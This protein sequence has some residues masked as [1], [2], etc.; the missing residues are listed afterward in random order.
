MPSPNMFN[1]YV[2]DLIVAAE[3]AKQVVTVGEDTV[4][5]LLF[6]DDFVGISET[7]QGLQNK[8]EKA[9]RVE[10]TRKWWVTANAKKC[11]VVVCNEDK[12][13]PVNFCWK[14]GEDELSIVDQYTYLGVE[15]LEDSSS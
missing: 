1:L 8:T 5:G 15:I 10:Y 12:V 11:A 9:L 2:S 4:S 7:S 14:W 13:N 3:A 6:T